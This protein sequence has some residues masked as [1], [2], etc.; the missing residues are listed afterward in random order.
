[1]ILFVQAEQIADRQTVQAKHDTDGRHDNTRML[2]V[3]NNQL[4]NHHHGSG[5]LQLIVTAVKM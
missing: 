1:V 3:V 2:N 4:F 5:D